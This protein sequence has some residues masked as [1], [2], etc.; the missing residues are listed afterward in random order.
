MYLDIDHLV[1][2]GFK[3]VLRPHLSILTN[4]EESKKNKKTK[5]EEMM[6]RMNE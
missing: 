6:K 4:K 1:S 2:K 3:F 5:K